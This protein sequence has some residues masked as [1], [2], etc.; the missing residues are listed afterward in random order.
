MIKYLIVMCV[1]SAGVFFA[2]EVMKTTDEQAVDENSAQIKEYIAKY[3]ENCEKAPNQKAR[4]ICQ[5][6]QKVGGEI[7]NRPKSATD[8]YKK[9]I[10]GGI[11]GVVAKFTPDCSG[12]GAA[13]KE[14]S[15]GM[16]GMI[17]ESA[18][19]FACG[20]EAVAEGAKD[21]FMES[22]DW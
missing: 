21:D 19:N 15:S 12:S 8:Y 10:M 5:M 6:M 14:A 7:E 20:V 18:F 1:L 2:I 16:V 4:S 3:G 9:K 13:P 17:K 22:E 11:R